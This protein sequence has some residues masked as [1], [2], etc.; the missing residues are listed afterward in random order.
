V[1]LTTGELVNKVA[2]FAAAIVLARTL[3]LDDFGAVNVGIAVAGIGLMA[4]SL[5]LP[6]V[7][8]RDVAAYPAELEAVAARVLAGRLLALLVLT[9]IGIGIVAATA[10]DGLD[11]AVLVAAMAVGLAVSGDWALRGLGRMATLAAATAAGGIAVLAGVVLVLPTAPSREL[12]IALFAASELLVAALTWRALGVLPIPRLRRSGLP[13]L[14]R[15]SWPAGASALIVYS[16]YANLDTIFLAAFRSDEEAGLYSAPYRVFLALNVLGTFAAYALLPVMTRLVVAGRERVAD[17]EL[18]RRL[19]PLMCYGLVVLGAVEVAGAHL[20][21]LLFGSEFG[22]MRATLIILCSTIPWYSVAFPCGYTRLAHEQGRRFLTGAAVAG[23]LN[24]LLDL[25]L[26]P[27]LGAE[28]A[29]VATLIALVAGSAA[30]LRAARVLDRDGIRLLSM[31]ALSL[32]T[33]IVAAVSAAAAPWT[34]AIV[35]MAGVV[36][37]VAEWRRSAA[38]PD[39]G[40]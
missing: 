17:T 10:P 13:A 12:A 6:E 7:G 32:A 30:W 24:L 25:G 22:E 39:R 26:I 5:G 23:T 15:R 3:S 9:A 37:G 34:G 1:A 21:E 20:L 18:R 8:S 14:L 16:Y 4:T 38:R 28:G 33:G 31:L 40:P 29:A 27:L 36:G 11:L 2:R 35:L 19:A